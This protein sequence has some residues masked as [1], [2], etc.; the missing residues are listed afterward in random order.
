MAR[1]VLL[2]AVSLLLLA[3]S[4][5]D[6]GVAAFRRR[7]FPAAESALRRSLKQTPDKTQARLYL[8][9]T[10]IEMD[11]ISEAL[12]ELQRAAKQTSDI[13]ARFQAGKILQ[14]LGSRRFSDLRRTAPGSA[15]VLELSGRRWEL[16]GRLAEALADYRAAAQ[17][18]PS[19]AGIQ[20]L[21]GNVLWRQRDL[22]AAEAALRQELVRN[23]F[24]GLANLR[25]G[26]V[27]LQKDDAAA[28]VP[29][30][31]LAVKAMPESALAPRELGKVY[32]KLGRNQDAMAQ[33]EPVARTRPHDDQVHFLLGNLYRELGRA[34]DAQRELK[35]HRAVLEQR[36]SQ[37]QK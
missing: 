32:R 24:H 37:N 29:P 31:E 18:D 7:D 36:R 11:R 4:D 34:G 23:P 15:E 22:P 13:E 1:L 20:Y 8:A 33:W 14:E 26:Q 19:R 35:Q 16:E 30:L 17:K 2:F 10:L 28:A 5:F 21:I 9:R 12:T 3:S 27:L 6:Q 25:L